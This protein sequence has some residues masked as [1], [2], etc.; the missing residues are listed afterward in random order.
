MVPHSSD[1]QKLWFHIA[2]SQHCYW[3][4]PLPL[5][6]Q[7]DQSHHSRPLLCRLVSRPLPTALPFHSHCAAEIKVDYLCSPTALFSWNSFHTVVS[8]LLV[9]YTHLLLSYRS[10][11]L[12]VFGIGI[13]HFLVF[14]SSVLA[15]SQYSHSSVLG[16]LSS[17]WTALY[18]SVLVSTTLSFIF[19]HPPY[20]HKYHCYSYTSNSFFPCGIQLHTAIQ[21]DPLTVHSSAH[22]SLTRLKQGHLIST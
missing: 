14:H 11:Y 5:Q 4:P 17:L 10:Q 22:W 18:K 20:P 6:L 9:S 2:W 15:P 3:T 12:L 16:S 8:H 7:A 13:L 19:L 1:I 21:C